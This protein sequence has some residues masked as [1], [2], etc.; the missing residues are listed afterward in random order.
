LGAARA[1]RLTAMVPTAQPVPSLRHSG[2]AILLGSIMPAG[3][4]ANLPRAPDAAHG[5]GGSCVARIR[6]SVRGLWPDAGK[7]CNSDVSLSIWHAAAI[8]CRPKLPSASSG[9]PGQLLIGNTVKR[10]W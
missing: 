2:Y 3:S 4:S 9:H 6:C 5:F 1:T 8:A 10:G 7:N